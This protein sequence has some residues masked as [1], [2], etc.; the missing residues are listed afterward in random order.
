[1]S[2]THK[3]TVVS[4]RLCSCS[5]RKARCFILFIN[6]DKDRDSESSTFVLMTHLIDVYTDLHHLTGFKNLLMVCQSELLTLT[7]KDYEG[8]LKIQKTPEIRERVKFLKV[9]MLYISTLMYGDNQ[10]IHQEW[11]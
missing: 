8:I 11:M 9:C 7:K 6:P 1:M 3:G 5:L 4:Q 2:S 10:L